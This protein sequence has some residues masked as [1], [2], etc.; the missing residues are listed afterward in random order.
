MDTGLTPEDELELYALIDSAAEELR[1]ACGDS[2]DS[3][4]LKLAVDFEAEPPSRE[5]MVEVLRRLR[6]GRRMLSDKSE[7]ETSDP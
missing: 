6:E 7:G 2:W 4:R 5:Q 3:V 1:E